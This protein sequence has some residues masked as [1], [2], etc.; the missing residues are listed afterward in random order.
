MAERLEWSLKTFR[1]S[2]QELSRKPFVKA[3]W[4]AHLVFVPNAIKYNVPQNPNV[5]K[6]WAILWDEL[7]ECALK[8]EAYQQI[9]S[10]LE[11][12]NEGLGKVFTEVCRNDSRKQ[13]QEQKQEQESPLPPTGVAMCVLSEFQQFWEVYPKKVGKKAAWTAWRTATDR[14]AT[15]QIL[16][17]VSIFKQSE[18]WTREKGRYIPHPA[19]WI[20][21]GRW[22]DE[23]NQRLRGPRQ[24]VL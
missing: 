5:V 10:F 16:Q 23:F 19:T 12:V 7:P 1:E 2:F 20:H 13:E 21:Q 11:S 8:D 6:G 17:A 14:P 15:E 3:D 22:D 9:K 4:K 18:Q 24:V